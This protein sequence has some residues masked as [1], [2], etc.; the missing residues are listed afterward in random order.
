MSGLV[1]NAFTE[2]KHVRYTR[3]DSGFGIDEFGIIRKDGGSCLCESRRAGCRKQEY[4][5]KCG[6]DHGEHNR[7][8][9]CKGVDGGCK[10]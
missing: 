5:G 10:K 3:A 1:S 2:A 7:V 8:G 6:R 4:D 9:R